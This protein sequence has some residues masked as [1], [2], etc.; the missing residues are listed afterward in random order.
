[1]LLSLCN[2]LAEPD[3]EVCTA[4]YRL[5]AG[6][7]MNTTI[8]LYI[9]SYKCS[10]ITSQSRSVGSIV[11]T[12]PAAVAYQQLCMHHLLPLVVRGVGSNC[13]WVVCSHI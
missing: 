10:C 5:I 12:M 1:M 13:G 9:Y 2:T 3:A 6:R 4:M 11:T 7:Q 8:Y